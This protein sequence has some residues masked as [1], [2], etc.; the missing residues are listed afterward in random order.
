[1]MERRIAMLFPGQGSQYVGMGK[2]LWDEFAVAR[3]TFQEA[4]EALGQ[5]VAGLCF[6]GPEERLRLTANTQPAILTVSVAALRVIRSQIPMTPICAAGHS[7]GEYSALVAAGVLGF[8]D[9]VALVRKR[10]QFMQEAVPEGEGAMAALLGLEGDVVEALCRENAGSRV[11]T[12][13]NYNGPGQ[14]VI[15]GHADAVE[16]V[17]QS[18]KG[19]GVRKAVMLPVSAPFHSPLMA[20]AGERLREEIKRISV[21]PFAFEVI[22]NVE[23]APY[24]SGEAVA[25]L[26]SRQVSHPVRW[27]QCME[28]VS[29]RGVG[30]ALE[31]GPKNVLTGLMKRIAP[32]VQAIPMEDRKGLDMVA[33]LVS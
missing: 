7:L 19:H 32:Q 11:V 4:S 22:S 1:M 3:Q 29:A 9:A 10:G 5:D 20:P 14:M 18:A 27:Q 17:V 8:A 21:G 31:L 28:A 33:K 16:R 13:A 24:P 30:L 6:E 2:A 25:D 26:L 12:P 23:A 15:S